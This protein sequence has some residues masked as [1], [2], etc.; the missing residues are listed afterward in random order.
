MRCPAS[1]RERHLEQRGQGPVYQQ[2]QLLPSRL[3]GFSLPPPQ[4]ADPEI[5]YDERGSFEGRPLEIL[6]IC[7]R[8][9][10]LVPAVGD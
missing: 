10:G 9:G 2:L 5:G 7:R 3:W 4:E 8:D 1:R 6:R